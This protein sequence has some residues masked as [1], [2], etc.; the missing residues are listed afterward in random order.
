MKTSQYYSKQAGGI[1]WSI[2]FFVIMGPRMK[3]CIRLFGRRADL[4]QF[5]FEIFEDTKELYD[6]RLKSTVPQ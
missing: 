4:A 2:H 6:D 1:I 3:M 5:V